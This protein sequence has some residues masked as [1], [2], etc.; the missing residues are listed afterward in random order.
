MICNAVEL[1][2]DR[3]HTQVAGFDEPTGLTD[4]P[5]ILSENKQ[6]WAMLQN[7]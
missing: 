2:S 3:H 4:K 5:L 7:V 6:S 1:L